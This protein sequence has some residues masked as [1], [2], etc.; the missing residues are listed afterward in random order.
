MH[1]EHP[2]REVGCWG[3]RGIGDDPGEVV[4]VGF[5]KATQTYMWLLVATGVM[6][7][8]AHRRNMAVTWGLQYRD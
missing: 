7:V 8:K 5:L 4:R 1:S 6:G 2:R 3:V